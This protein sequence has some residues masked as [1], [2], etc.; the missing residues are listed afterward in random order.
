VVQA[1]LD[2]VVTI[3]VLDEGDDVQVQGH[4][5]SLD[6]SLR[7]EKVDHLLNRAGTVHVEGDLDEVSGDRL[8]QRV[9]LFV[10]AVLEELLREVVAKWIY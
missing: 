1:L 3:E 2:D 7:R 9:P 10:G 8:D 4:D 6:L 5:E